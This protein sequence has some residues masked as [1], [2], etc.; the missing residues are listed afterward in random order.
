MEP[1]DTRLANI[2]PAL[3]EKRLEILQQAVPGTARLA[4]LG[5]PSQRDRQEIGEAGVVRYATLHF[6]LAA[7][8]QQ[9]PPG[10]YRVW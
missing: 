6:R 7:D 3:T 5:K 1:Q 8:C 4:V 9:L 10:G 2:A